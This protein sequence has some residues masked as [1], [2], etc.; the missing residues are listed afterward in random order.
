MRRWP[1]VGARQHGLARADS[2]TSLVRRRRPSAAAPAAITASDP[3]PTRNV[4]RCARGRL[5]LGAAR[6]RSPNSVATPAATARTAATLRRRVR[7]RVV[8]VR[9]QADDAEAGEAGDAR[10]TAGASTPPRARAEGDRH[11]DDAD[12]EGD[13]VVRP[14]QRD[15]EVLQLGGEAVDELRADRRH[16]RRGRP[17]E[18]ADELA[19]A[20]RH[21]CGDGAGDRAGRAGQ[22]HAPSVS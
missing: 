6:R 3:A 12:D 13:L 18:S 22:S 10:P 11:D 21:P 15:G 14:E 9:Q 5:E 2:T 20:E 7:L 1:D 17:G 19:D 16:Q 8:E 4:R